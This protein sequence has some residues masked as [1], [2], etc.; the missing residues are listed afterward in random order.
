M[1][2]SVVQE[3]STA[4]ASPELNTQSLAF[5]S[6][7]AIGNAIEVHVHHGST[8]ATYN[9][10]QSIT[11]DQGQTYSFGS[12]YLSTGSGAQISVYYLN[13]N[14]HATALDITASWVGGPNGGLSGS[15]PAMWI[16]EIGGVTATAYQTSG[17]Q[18]QNSPGTGANAITTGNVTPTSQ[19]ALLSAL[20]IND[21]GTTPPASA[22]T[23]FT[24]GTT[25]M[26]SSAV[27]ESMRLTSTSAVAA[28]F[29]DA[30]NGGGYIFDTMAVVW[31]EAGAAGAALAG[32]PISA[33]TATG[34]LSTAIKMGGAGSSV[35]AAA[36]ALLNYASVVLG[37]TV[38]A[39][40]GSILDPNAQW[41]AGAPY[42]G[43]TVYYDATHISILSDGEVVSNSNNT[44]A[45]AQWYN[46]TTW[47]QLFI[48]LTPNMVSY[49]NA[50]SVALA[51]M[52]TAIQLSAA[53]T[54]LS[55]A[56]AGLTTHVPLA[57]AAA[58]LSAATSTLNTAIRLVAA[59]VDTSTASGTLF[60]LDSIAGNAV[61]T[62]T[63]T[64]NL[65]AQ[66]VLIA[67]AAVTVST[68]AAAITTHIM[69]AANAASASAASGNMTSGALLF[70][71]AQ[72]V[73]LASAALIN[74]IKLAAPALAASYASAQ[75]STQISL[76]ANAATDSSSGFGTL[77]TFNALN[78]NAQSLSSAG[79]QISTVISMSG[80]AF[81]YLNANADMNTAVDLGGD[82]V[83]GSTVVATFTATGSPV[84]LYT[85]DPLFVVTSQRNGYTQRFPMVGP[86]E[87]HVLSFDYASS[88]LTGEVMQGR[89]NVYVVNSA[90]ED[91][92]P[93]LILT[94]VAGY[95]PTLTLVEQ[96]VQPVLTDNDYYF[97]VVAPTTTPN[98]T[99]AAFGLL[100]VRG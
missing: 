85:E 59:A 89:I 18:T 23:G 14:L 3:N 38:Y 69:A 86:G 98:K 99:L 96:P 45:L 36:A 32:A 50:V 54:S 94:A 40:I 15:Y 79:A 4:V 51:T 17:G 73:S 67:Q 88:L 43:N 65:L 26:S 53:A 97:T 52:S 83:S 55:S 16:K 90:G 39:G 8:S 2:A 56:A 80:I 61:S 62:D 82:A 72:A 5:A 60:A 24:S 33:S 100:S 30:T 22:G 21:T 93:G 66:I 10:P 91:Q 11:D 13:D 48:V 75:L 34:A 77:T 37:P 49:A 27:S 58:D 12:S 20:C 47:S 95:D 41:T 6:A 7:C 81:S 92:N 84:G 9:L 25:G 31:N 35:S 46:G 71:N 63:A 42:V 68:A 57:G 78:S 28:T 74:Q 29:T 76:A 64:G 44:V 1:T 70:G 87:V 19:P